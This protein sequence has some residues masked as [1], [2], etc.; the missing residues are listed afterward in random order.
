MTRVNV[1]P[2]K[3]LC[4]QHLS[5]EW[6]EMPRI[7]GELNRSLNRKSKP[8]N[9]K[10]I[11]EDYVLGKGHVKFFFDK[12][13]FLHQRHISLTKELLERGFKLN[14]TNSDVFTTV[15]TQWYNDYEPTQNAK[16]IN[17]QR[18]QTMMPKDPRFEVA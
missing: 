2:P 16:E 13:K 12:F 10:E 15:D 5:A 4:N 11:P 18:I 7:V 17:R 14:L 9:T 6:R 8:F 1:V 3:E